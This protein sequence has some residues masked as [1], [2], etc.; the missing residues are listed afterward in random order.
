MRT[1]K[2]VLMIFLILT[3]AM[4]SFIGC[5]KETSPQ[6]N[7]TETNNIE[8][9]DTET[10]DSESKGSIIM[11]T[12]TST[13]NSG[14]LDDIL[15]HFK[16]ETG[17]DVKVV[18]VGTGKALEMGRQGEADVLLVHAK[19]SEEEFVEEGH[20]TERFDVMYND[21][22][23]IGPKDDP[24][25]LSEKSKSDVIEAFK[26]LSSGESKFISRGDDSGTHKKELSFWQEA[27][28]EPEG[29]WYVSA[30]KGMGDV[31]QMTNEMLGYT[32]S[33]RATYLSMKDKI[34]LE[35]VVEGDSKLF[36]QYGVIPVNP[37]KDDKINSDGAKAF[38][39]W[40]LSEQTQ[41]LI[42]EFGK[43]KFGQPLFTPNA[44]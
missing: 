44:K 13:E 25:K 34:E 9:N 6:S 41:K 38:V 30:G 32:M 42:G 11:A 15:P 19:S 23:I 3:L 27:S 40:I 18:A 7:N 33:D 22:V 5:S 21:F 17:I 1:G 4:T 35:V 36:N 12:T 20:G 16:D 37:D 39:D 8:T 26:L 43:E 10:N 24:A 14:L 2:K 29:D 31:I 28:I